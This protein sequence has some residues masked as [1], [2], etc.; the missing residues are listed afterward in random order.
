MDSD[1]SRPQRPM[2]SET[3]PLADEEDHGRA[4]GRV[5]ATLLAAPGVAVGLVVWGLVLGYHFGRHLML[6]WLED[7]R[8]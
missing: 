2:L 8:G 6:S 7:H 4:L 3:F 5:L 1:P